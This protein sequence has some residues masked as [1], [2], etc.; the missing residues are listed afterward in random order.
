[1]RPRER[2]VDSFSIVK[3]IIS[4][5]ANSRI[6][7]TTPGKIKIDYQGKGCRGPGNGLYQGEKRQR[8]MDISRTGALGIEGYRL[9]INKDSV[10]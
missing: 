4:N 9:L 5:L 7:L 8:D 1:M 2:E 10:R 6:N 3:S